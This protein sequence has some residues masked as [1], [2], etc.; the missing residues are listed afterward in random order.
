MVSCSAASPFPW[1]RP[2][3]FRTFFWELFGHLTPIKVMILD[4]INNRGLCLPAFLRSKDRSAAKRSRSW[5]RSSL[6]SLVIFFG[7]PRSQWSVAVHFEPNFPG[8]MP[9]AISAAGDCSNRNPVTSSDA[10]KGPK[11]KP[12][13]PKH[14]S[15]VPHGSNWN[16]ET[17]L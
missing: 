16:Q 12:K 14:W 13:P 8:S 9:G 10:Q 2:N 6:F 11:T 17:L 4:L 7:P 1:T 3:N 5:S 15:L